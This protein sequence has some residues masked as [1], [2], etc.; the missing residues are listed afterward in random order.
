MVVRVAGT[1]EV[2]VRTRSWWEKRLFGGTRRR[3][4]D[5]IKKDIQ[6]IGWKVEQ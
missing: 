4:K 3:G 1:G 6:E 2:G 5:N